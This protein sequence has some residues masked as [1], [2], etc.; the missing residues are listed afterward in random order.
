MQFTRHKTKLPWPSQSPDPIEDLWD[1][2]LPADLNNFYARFE[3][4]AQA[5]CSNTALLPTTEE[6]PEP[7]EGFNL[8]S[9][10]PRW[11]PRAGTASLCQPAGLNFTDIFNLSLA[12]STVPVCFKATTIIPIPQKSIITGM[13][14]YRPIALTP[15]AMKCFERLI[16][17]HI[18]RSLPSTLDPPQFAYRANR[19]TDDEVSL[20]I[21]TALNHLDSTNSYVRM[22]FVD[23]SS[24]F[25]TI[26]LSRL[27]H[28]LNTLGINNTLCSWITDFLTCRPQCENTSPSPTLSTGRPQGIVLSPI[29][30]H[31]VHPRLHRNPQFQHH[32]QVC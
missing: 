26:L 9:R 7:E 19:S 30:V 22:L 14:H 18:K 10:G 13:N 27:I 23:F 16:L 31:S 12:R 17:S 32:H 21:H 1:A 5:Q 8:D 25:N 2:A 29:V 3:T 28:K 6:E 4:S 24:A 11:H 15:I 20:A